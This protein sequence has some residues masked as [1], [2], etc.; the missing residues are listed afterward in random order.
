MPGT[1]TPRAT[2]PN[3][4]QGN[5]RVQQQPLPLPSQILPPVPVTSMK[6]LFSMPKP[7]TMPKP[8][9]TTSKKDLAKKPAPEKRKAAYDSS[10]E[11]ADSS[12]DL[13]VAGGAPSAPKRPKAVVRGDLDIPSMAS[14]PGKVFVSSLNT[15]TLGSP[16][17][18]KGGGLDIST[19]YIETLTSCTDIEAASISVIRGLNIGTRSR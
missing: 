9:S 2:L 15:N 19:T 17:R 11:T 18:Y 13:T 5:S 10:Q 6:P 1:S 7:L 12:I 14:I 16:Y 4:G 3:F 8:K